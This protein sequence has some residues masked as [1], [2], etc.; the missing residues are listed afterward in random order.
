MAF[1]YTFQPALKFVVMIFLW[2]RSVLNQ[3]P[4]HIVKFSLIFTLFSCFLEVFF[5]LCGIYDFSHKF[6]TLS[7][8]SSKVL[9]LTPLPFSISSNHYAPAPSKNW[10]CSPSASVMIAFFHERLLPRKAPMRL[11]LQ[12]TLIV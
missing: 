2:Q 3:E 6:L 7:L 11:G 1:A 9:H 4:N 12:W 5:V 8:Y 10:I